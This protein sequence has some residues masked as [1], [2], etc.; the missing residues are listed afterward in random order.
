MNQFTCKYKPPNKSFRR[1]C[2]QTDI[3]FLRLSGYEHVSLPKAEPGDLAEV[4]CLNC[5]RVEPGGI[6]VIEASSS[7][8]DSLAQLMDYVFVSFCELCTCVMTI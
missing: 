6:T 1:T 4:T 3:T 2:Y 7:T 5:R 8:A